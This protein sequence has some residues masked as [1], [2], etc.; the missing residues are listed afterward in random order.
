M[1]YAEDMEYNMAH[2]AKVENGIVTNVIVAEQDV[3]NSGVLGDPTQ[4]IQTSYNGSIRQHYAGIGYLYLP[5][6]DIFIPPKPFTSWTLD[7]Q[8]GEW[9]PPQPKPTDSNKVF[10]WDESTLSWKEIT[11]PLPSPIIGE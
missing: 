8:T 5:D 7:N 9:L 2:F 10:T 6:L 4:W 3:I 1:H 11:N